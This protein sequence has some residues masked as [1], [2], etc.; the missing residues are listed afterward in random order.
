MAGDSL[1]LGMEPISRE[2][3]EQVE[4]KIYINFMQIMRPICIDFSLIIQEMLNFF[5][6]LHIHT[7][8]STCIRVLYCIKKAME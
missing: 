1:H 2:R 3:E 8:S 4:N 7:I 5:G 6:G